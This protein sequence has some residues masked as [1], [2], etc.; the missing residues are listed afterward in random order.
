LSRIINPESAG[1]ERKQYC[2]MIIRPLR[3]MMKKQEVDNVC[4]DM[5]AFIAIALARIDE[6][7]DVSVA[8][9]EKKGYWVKA[10]RFR[11]DW[12]WAGIYGKEMANAV[13]ENNWN[14][15]AILSVK[16]ADKLKNETLP[17]R[18]KLGTPWEGAFAQLL[19][20]SK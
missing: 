14:S 17:V 11:M 12:R 13:F 18:H 1:K 5:V 9:W 20:E 16:I 2:R 6:T 15:S 3:E 19:Q 7:I 4:K 8:A 10:D